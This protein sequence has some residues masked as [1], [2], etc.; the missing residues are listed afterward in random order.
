MSQQP[1]G[2][3]RPVTRIFLIGIM[4]VESNWVHSA[5]WPPMAY[6]AS[7]GWLWW[8]RNWWNDDWQ[9]K[10]KYSEKTCPSAALSTANPT[11]CSDANPGGR[12]GK[13]V[14]NRLCYGTAVTGIALPLY[15]CTPGL[16][17]TGGRNIRL[18][19]TRIRDF[20][21]FAY[22]RKSI[23]NCSLISGCVRKTIVDCWIYRNVR[24]S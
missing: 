7:P 15:L 14:T 21:N 18:I 6:C 4:W 19:I 22:V 20:G 23:D 16:R 3:L 24:L 10:P 11:C 2:S 13:P 8:C 9:G 12:G 1:Y 5:L 17:N